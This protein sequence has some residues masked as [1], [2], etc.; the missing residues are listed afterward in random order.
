M[1]LGCPRAQG[2]GRLHEGS[3]LQVSPVGLEKHLQH[4]LGCQQPGNGQEWPCCGTFSIPGCLAAGFNHRN[5]QLLLSQFLLQSPLQHCKTWPHISAIWQ[6]C[7]TK[8]KY[9]NEDLMRISFLFLFLFPL[10][11]QLCFFFLLWAN[12]LACLC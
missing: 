12:L 6:Y 11:F 9:I 3:S 8:D 2:R 7:C 10:C 4:M 1:G 5:Q